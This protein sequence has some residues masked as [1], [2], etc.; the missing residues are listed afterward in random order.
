ML[1]ALMRDDAEQMQAVEMIGRRFEHA[2]IN[3]FRIRQPAG[4][5]QCERMREGIQ[6]GHRGRTPCGRLR[7]ARFLAD[8]RIQKIN[9]AGRP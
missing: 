3:L 2:L 5:M 9:Y 6:C 7:T 4:L 1:A 8:T